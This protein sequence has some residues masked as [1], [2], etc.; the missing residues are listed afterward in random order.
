QSLGVQ[1][2]GG[3][4]VIYNTVPTTGFGNESIKPE[5]KQEVEFG[6][7]TRLYNNRLGFDITY[8]NGRIQDQI[9]DYT[10][11]ISMGSGSI[12]ANVGT[13][14]NSGWEFAITGAPIRNEDFR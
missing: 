12:L 8:Y 4:A 3:A 13:L 10:L 14:R 6:L 11:P 9:L 2:E 5:R 7:E 1:R